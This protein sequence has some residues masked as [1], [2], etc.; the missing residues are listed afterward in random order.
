MASSIGITIIDSRT[1]EIFP[2]RRME[3]NFTALSS[4]T[5]IGFAFQQTYG[6]WDID[7]IILW[8]ERILQNRF[9]NGDF[10]SGSLLPYYRQCRSAGSISTDSPFNSRYHYT[11]ST[12][13][14]FGFLMQNVSIIA[15]LRYS[16]SFDL[17]NRGGSN[18]TFMVLVGA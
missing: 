2:Y 17:Q 8:D 15:G 10:E 1:C 11:D 3:Y 12:R 7:N 18:S 13:S 5:T 4:R 9:R 16:L 6:Y 14:R